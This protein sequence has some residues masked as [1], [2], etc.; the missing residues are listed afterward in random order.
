MGGQTAQT[1]PPILPDMGGLDHRS[2]REILSPVICGLFA[3]PAACLCP[4]SAED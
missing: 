2:L 1:N 4:A 3:H